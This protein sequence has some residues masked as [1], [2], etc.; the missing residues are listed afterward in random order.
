[1]T[2][3]QNV[4]AGDGDI[5]RDLVGPLASFRSVLSGLNITVTQQADTIT[6]AFLYASVPAD[7]NAAGVK[8]QVSFDDSFFYV[9]INNNSWR[10]MA[11]GSWS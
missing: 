3:I 1:M 4:G 5:F 11:L 6:V 2:A 10:R 9:C 8:G 7:I